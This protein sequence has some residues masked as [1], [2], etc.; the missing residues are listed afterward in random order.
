MAINVLNNWNREL[1]TNLLQDICLV[2]ENKNYKDYYKFE[3]RNIEGYDYMDIKPDF[4]YK[5]KKK[6]KFR[7][8][9][10]HKEERAQ[11]YMFLNC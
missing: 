1:N 7:L 9:L 6:D 11:Q 3:I 8:G 5:R 10:P 2:Y 4:I